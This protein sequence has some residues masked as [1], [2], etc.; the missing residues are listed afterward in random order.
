MYSVACGRWR[1]AGEKVHDHRNVP[2]A[3]HRSPLDLS[4]NR[5]GSNRDLQEF[6]INWQS[7]E[8]SAVKLPSLRLNVRRL[9]AV[10]GVVAVVTFELIALLPEAGWVGHAWVPLEFLILDSS[11]G[12]PI[13]RATLRLVETNPEYQAITGP[14]GRRFGTSPS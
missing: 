12:Q 5:R 1:F 6:T 9:M 14:D 2:I 11:T 7:V 13:E 4:R 8:A 10:V 3:R